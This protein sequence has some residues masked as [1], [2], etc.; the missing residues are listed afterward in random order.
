MPIVTAVAPES[1]TFHWKGHY[2]RE[3]RAIDH[4]FA[5]EQLR[6]LGHRPDADQLRTRTELA[7][8]IARPRAVI[9][10]EAHHL[11]V[12][13]SP[14]QLIKQLEILKSHAS[15]STTLFVLVGTYSLINFRNLNGQLSRRSRD[16]HFPR[17]RPVNDE[18]VAFRETVVQLASKVPIPADDLADFWDEI[19]ERTAGCVGI[20]KDWL[21][22][23]LALAL[24]EPHPRLRWSH[25]GQTAMSVSSMK[26]IA[27]EIRAGEQATRDDDRERDQLRSLLGL[28]GGVSARTPKETGDRPKSRARR[29][30]ERRP[31]R[32]RV[33]SPQE[34]M[35]ASV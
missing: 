13:A 23:A 7:L 10:D 22:R 19:Y 17:Y 14:A 1:T 24:H 18:L 31:E 27:E 26:A 11:G 15:A 29:P 20:L 3:L 21:T 32:D 30:G 9:I 28:P 16:I 5:H 35:T 25:L 12:G 6:A 34:R 4:P 2:G 33:L 8:Q